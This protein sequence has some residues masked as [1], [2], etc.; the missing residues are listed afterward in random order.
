MT[1]PVLTAR[2]FYDH[3]HPDTDYFALSARCTTPEPAVDDIRTDSANV[4]AQPEHEPPGP[5]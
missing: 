3:T 2:S 4:L 1:D 5:G